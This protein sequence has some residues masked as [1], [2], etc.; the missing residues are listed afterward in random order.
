MS[1]I[2]FDLDGTLIDSAPDIH[3]TAVDVLA[4]EGLPGITLAETRSF[5]GKGVPALIAQCLAANGI[6]EEPG[7]DARIVAA[8]REAYVSAVGR[9]TLYPGVETCLRGL[10]ADGFRLGLCT[11]KPEAPTWAVLDHFGLSGLFDA[12]TFGDGAFPP[13][14][15]P[16]A[17]RHI[18]DQ[19]AARHFLYVGDSETDAATA[20]HAGIPLALYTEGY[21]K[22]PVVEMPHDAAFSHFDELRA[23]VDRLAPLPE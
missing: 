20:Q 3:A 14:P 11:N 15:D 22:S 18:V 16:A 13:K 9:T 4:G 23:I 8:F 1:G 12:F 7:R 17:L 19:L 10:H 2:I 5:I 6:A 21:R